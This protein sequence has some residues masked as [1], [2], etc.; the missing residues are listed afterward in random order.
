MGSGVSAQ[1]SL[2]N[3][4]TPCTVLPS[5]SIDVRSAPVMTHTDIQKC[6]KL[7]QA[8]WR[9]IVEF[10][11][12]S[13]PCI[14]EESKTGIFLF[15]SKVSN[16]LCRHKHGSI[17]TE[18]LNY[19]WSRKKMEIVFVALKLIL[20]MHIPSERAI[21]RRLKSLG[22]EHSRLG[23][24]EELLYPF[25]DAIVTSIMEIILENPVINSFQ[26][27]NNVQCWIALFRY[28]VHFMTVEKI[29]FVRTSSFAETQGSLSLSNENI[30][31]ESSTFDNMTISMPVGVVLDS[32][33]GWITDSHPHELVECEQE[34]GSVAHELHV[35]IN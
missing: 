12:S 23:I 33:L 27:T 26:D 28:V 20:S 34:Y 29:K 2:V 18:K 35:A 3:K 31:V 4:F 1:K 24:D 8:D 30:V 16:Y 17:L 25:C 14:H 19:G 13:G 22:R 15:C 7:C 21:L 10:R 6:V 11:I 9:N 5:G 32:E